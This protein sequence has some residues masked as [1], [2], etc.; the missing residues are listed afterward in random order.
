MITPVSL[1]KDTV[2]G[3]RE[4]YA[5]VT[6]VL[7]ELSE[8]LRSHESRNGC[9]ALIEARGLQSQVDTVRNFIA[10]AGQPALYS[11]TRSSARGHLE[12]ISLTLATT[13]VAVRPVRVIDR[14][15]ITV[16]V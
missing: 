11:P 13:A 16:L 6:D 15:G 1:R 12:E 10:A 3:M 14:F 8:A 7:R 4:L 2:S 5:S 9:A